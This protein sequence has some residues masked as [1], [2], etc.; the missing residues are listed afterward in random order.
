M[1]KKYNLTGGILLSLILRE[2]KQR[3]SKRSNTLGKTDRLNDYEVL[4]ELVKIADTKVEINNSGS[5]TQIASKFRACESNNGN[6]IPLLKNDYI[7]EFKNGMTDKYSI[8]LSRT[9]RF[10]NTYIET[11]E[12]NI[13]RL[14]QSILEMIYLDDSIDNDAEFYICDNKNP[15]KKSDLTP[16][17]SYE[18]KPLLLGVWHYIVVSKI[19]NKTGKDTFNSIHKKSSDGKNECIFKSSLYKD[20][21]ISFPSFQNE[22]ETIEEDEIIVENPTRVKYEE[23]ITNTYETL[24]KVRTLI[25]PQ[26]IDFYQI[27]VSSEIGIKPTKLNEDRRTLPKA[28]P[29]SFIDAFGHFTTISAN[30][31]MGKSMFMKHMFLSFKRDWGKDCKLIPIFISLKDYPNEDIS[32]M[33]YIYKKVEKYVSLKEFK[34]DLKTGSFLFLF[35]A[36]DEIKP[37]LTQDFV[38]KLEQFSTDYAENYFILSSRPST[39]ANSLNRFISLRLDPFKLEHSIFMIQK[40]NKLTESKNNFITQL[41]RLYYR[42]YTTIA[43]N[44]L[45]LTIMY[46][47]YVDKNDIPDLEYKFYEE[48]FDV[49][50]KKHDEIKNFNRNFKTQLSKSEFRKVIAELSSMI[51]YDFKFSFEYNKFEEVVDEINRKHGTHINVDHLLY[52]LHKNI[53][54]IYFE[55]EKYHFLH[56]S[57]QEYFTALHLSKL[58]DNELKA[59]IPQIDQYGLNYSEAKKEENNGILGYIFVNNFDVINMLRDMNYKK[60]FNCV[61]MPFLEDI[62][63]EPYGLDS[64]LSFLDK[65]HKSIVYTAAQT[66]EV[67]MAMGS[68][69]ARL[70][71]KEKAID[72]D[73]SIGY[74][75]DLKN[76]IDDYACLFEIDNPDGSTGCYLDYGYKLGD[77]EIKDKEPYSTIYNVPVKD[78]INNK[79]EFVELIEVIDDESYPLKMQYDGLYEYLQELKAHK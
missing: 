9:E 73:V 58:S 27:Y 13:S 48:A 54:I 77:E 79:D 32:I 33:E 29:Q 35:D 6:W 56:R 19:K 49:I 28:K 52:D 40:L 22:N 43:S 14:A 3:I 4:F 11:R 5:N 26:S 74:G 15:I 71:L 1:S 51:F 67:G 7:D 78:I 76:Y 53:E 34:E 59:M 60:Y 18:L 70:I 68:E 37:G 69:L 30:G 39:S 38:A 72:E 24:N 65:I 36:L 17:K 46:M 42:K 20:T 41:Q 31:G 55:N 21:L 45:M 10:I 64:Y 50:Y 25:F 2:K 23:Y 62:I 47:I 63:A 75:P 8:L 16:D 44:P 61:V 12:K 57:F 66:H